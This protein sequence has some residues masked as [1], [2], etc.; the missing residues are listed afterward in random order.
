MVLQYIC[1][2]PSPNSRKHPR[3]LRLPLLLPAPLHRPFPGIL[4]LLFIFSTSAPIQAAI[5]LAG[6]GAVV[7]QQ[8]QSSP[9]K[10]ISCAASFQNANLTLFQL[11]LQSLPS[12]SIYPRIK[13]AREPARPGAHSALQSH[14]TLLLFLPHGILHVNAS[15]NPCTCL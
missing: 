15:L 5:S 2:H 7:F 14:L 8:Q 9:C 6:T 10:P 4:S 11:F 1:N 12:F 3:H 13:T